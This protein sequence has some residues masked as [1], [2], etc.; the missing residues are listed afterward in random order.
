MSAYF[1]CE[2]CNE[3]CGTKRAYDKHQESNTHRKLFGILPLEYPCPSCHNTFSRR[4]G[5]KRHLANGQCSGPNPRGNAGASNAIKHGR[6]VSPAAVA[7]KHRRTTSPTGDHFPGVPDA[8]RDSATACLIAVSPDLND[9]DQVTAE[10]LPST[11][12]LQAKNGTTKRTFSLEEALAARTHDVDLTITKTPGTESA[13]EGAESPPSVVFQHTTTLQDE[14]GH[15]KAAAQATMA[16][17]TNYGN[18]LDLIALAKSLES[19]SFDEIKK[20]RLRSDQ[21]ITEARVIA[22]RSP[23]KPFIPHSFDPSS[24]NPD[25]QNRFF[26]MHSQPYDSL[27]AAAEAKRIRD[28]NGQKLVKHAANGHDREVYEILMYNDVD[29][30]YSNPAL[31]DGVPAAM[32]AAAYGHVKVLKAI[33]R[34]LTSDTSSNRVHIQLDIYE[35]ITAVGRSEEFLRGLKGFLRF[36][37]GT[38]ACLCPRDVR[39]GTICEQVARRP[40]DPS[41]GRSECCWGDKLRQSSWPD[42]PEFSRKGAWQEGFLQSLGIPTTFVRPDELSK[43][44]AHRIRIEADKKARG[45]VKQCS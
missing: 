18:V 38:V 44:E 9:V 11:A 32:I 45:Q 29:V 36:A 43:K 35:L 26:A 1:I 3:H 4:S 6:S 34:A 16:G 5:V 39:I 7:C 41:T 23:I 30:N 21:K 2:A 27:S 37:V 17:M 20:M 25:S 15:L 40:F 12:P 28:S 33:L 8:R 24:A 19:M 10:D 31:H 13:H 14:Q 22:Q 42:L